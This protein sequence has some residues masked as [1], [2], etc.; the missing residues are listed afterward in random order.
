MIPVL[1]SGCEQSGAEMD[2]ERSFR[3]GG[4]MMQ[5]WTRI[6]TN[7]PSRGNISFANFEGLGVELSEK[8]RCSLNILA[9]DRII[10]DG[11]SVSRQTYIN[12]LSP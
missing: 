2:F 6:G 3:I 10:G 7:E 11:L 9:L 8:E 12:L 5:I 1:L 4:L